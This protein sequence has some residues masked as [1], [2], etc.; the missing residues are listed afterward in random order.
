MDE[1]IEKFMP[2]FAAL[3]RDRLRQAMQTAKDRRPEATAGIVH[4]LHALG[5]EAGLLGLERVLVA[6]RRAEHAAQRFGKTGAESDAVAFV[7][8]LRSLE[9]AVTEATDG[10]GSS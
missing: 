3:A 7:E 5:G 2:R 10:I 6:A 4:E 8:H 9:S 1:L